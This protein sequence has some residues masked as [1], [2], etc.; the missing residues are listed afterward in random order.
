MKYHVAWHVLHVSILFDIWFLSLKI[1]NW[2][3]NH[4][5]NGNELGQKIISAQNSYS[6]GEKYSVGHILLH[7]V[8]RHVTK[9][10]N[11]RKTDYLWKQ[12]KSKCDS[13]WC[14]PSWAVIV[15]AER[16]T[17][18]TKSTLLSNL[19]TFDNS[20]LVSLKAKS[21]VRI[22]L[23]FNYSKYPWTYQTKKV[24]CLS[25]LCVLCFVLKALEAFWEKYEILQIPKQKGRYQ[26]SGKV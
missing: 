14:I 2:D 23:V 5:G 17:C 12:P 26:S 8:P 24:Y 7:V 6:A 19:M 25:G 10:Q 18:T 11:K 1:T 22:A 21:F 3:K 20:L 15:L 13:R 9:K 4:F 16:S